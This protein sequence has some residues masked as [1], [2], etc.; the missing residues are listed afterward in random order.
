[1]QRRLALLVLAGIAAG[2]MLFVAGRGELAGGVWAAT[3]VLALLPLLWRVI[4]DL[5]HGKLGV[6]LIA[7]LAMAGCLGLGQYLAGAVIALMLAGGQ[8]LEEFAAGRAERELTR[9]LALAPRVAHRVGEQEIATVA[10]EEIQA[11]DLLLI[12]PGEPLPVD[13]VVVDGAAVLDES[14]IT[15][16]SRPVDRAIGDRVASGA[17]NAGGPFRLRAAASAAASTYAGIV[18]LVEAARQA[19]AP[20][21]RLADRYGLAFLP[22]TLAIAGGTWLVTRNPVQALAVMV[23]A[24][25]CPLI[26]AAPVALVGGLSRAARRGILIKGGGA[27]EA[28]AAARILLLDKTGTV[29]TGVPEVERIETFGARSPAEVLRL[30]ASLDQVSLHVFAAAVVRAARER[31]LTLSFPRQVEERAGAGVRGEVEGRAVALGRL[32]WVSAASGESTSPTVRRVRRAAALEGATPVFVSVD[33]ELIGALVLRD[34][35]RPDALATLRALRACGIRR[36]VL[37]TGDRPEVAA[38]VGAAVGTDEVLAERTPEEKVAA[39]VAERENGPTMMVG[40]GV[41]DAPALAAAGVGVAMGERGA[42]ASSEV[43]DA[44]ITV[45]RLDRL[46]DA[47]QIARRSFA[48]ARQSV[49]GGMALSLVGMGFASVGLLTPLA[50]ALI[51]EAIDV[52]VI[53]NALRALGGGRVPPPRAEL[54]VGARTRRE[55]RDLLPGVE[56]LRVLADRLEGLSPE[57]VGSELRRAVAFLHEELLPHDAREDEHVYPLVAR[58]I[59]GADPTAPMVR[60]HLEIHHLAGLLARQAEELPPSGPDVDELRDLRRVLYGLHAILR[61]HFEQEEQHYLPLLEG[62]AAR[63]EGRRA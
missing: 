51:Q 37:L 8:S 9:L 16:E 48:I 44:V 17:I 3:T 30:A 27:L 20:F 47:K 32:D 56:A 46:V 60:A 15:G 4:V 39:V 49:F 10:I 14:T 40:D 45:D 43:A 34:P 53:L 11:G 35:L 63:F 58:Q 22:L 28:I 52:L 62:H 38:L 18:R 7:L 29:T 31:G 55:H 2:G 24:T 36:I 42:S 26:L 50:G 21:V 19:R 5:R 13:G 23:V 1:L 41:N 59:G 6:D 33:G 57:E 54:E 25:P 61:L 12:K